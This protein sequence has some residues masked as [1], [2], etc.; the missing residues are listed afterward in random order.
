MYR[1]KNVLG[2][3]LRRFYRP[4]YRARTSSVRLNNAAGPLLDVLRQRREHLWPNR[5][6]AESLAA[7]NCGEF[8]FLN[9]TLD[10]AADSQSG[11]EGLN[12][13]P[14][15]PRLWR[16]HLHYHESLLELAGQ[17]GPDVAWQLVE[18]WLGDIGNQTPH[19]D[20]DSWHPFCLSMRLPNWLM[21]AG[22][23]AMPNSLSQQFWKSVSEQVDWLW[24]NPEWDL[25]GNHLLENLR[26]LAIADAVLEGDVRIHRTELYR[27]IDREIETQVLPTGEHFERTP[28]YHALMLLAVLEIAEA[29]ELVGQRCMAAEASVRMADFLETVLHPDGGIPLFG[30]SVFA[31]TPDPGSLIRSLGFQPGKTKSTSGL[32]SRDDSAN[33]DYWVW[34]SGLG[35]VQ[36]HCLIFDTGNAACDLLPAHA[37]ADLLCVSASAYGKRFLVDTGTFDYEDT[38]QR[39]HCRSTF[40]HN[41][42]RV[43]DRSQF[44]VWSRFRMGRRGH[45]RGKTMGIGEGFG[46]CLA[47][48]DAY[49]DTGVR[50]TCRLIVVDEDHPTGFRWLIADWIDATASHQIS[51][52]LHI[53]PAFKVATIDT[54]LS[55]CHLISDL[56]KEIF[57]RSS[58]TTTLSKND[59][60][61]DF[62]QKFLIDR[63]EQSATVTGGQPLIWT[64]SS[65]D[66]DALP[67][68]LP[69]S[70]GCGIEWGDRVS[71]R[72]DFSN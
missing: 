68:I 16:F 20:P 61:P 64:L 55:I 12:W 62:G 56:P 33:D 72:I 23:E 51:S 3:Q 15:A 34:R 37:H 59:Y 60:Y 26:T 13:Q 38:P 4:A 35:S 66:D 18:S 19:A 25:G 31:E 27:W 39:A 63:I 14:D 5:Q 32:L 65:H 57:V 29:A 69:T 46:W 7:I 2:R 45:V 36:E 6:D 8:R 49:A 24:Q 41:T 43:N 11:L 17:E 22:T 10:L 28:T 42:A 52:P 54:N 44:D 70:N 48:H 47:W 9:Q 21:L 67:K 30:D 58:A 53:G 1:G 40:A 50:R 71:F